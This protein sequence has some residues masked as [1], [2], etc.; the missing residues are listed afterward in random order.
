MAEGIVWELASKALES[1]S[2]AA[3]EEGSSWWGARSDLKKLE[4]TIR[5][6][7][8]RVRD[9]ERRQE[10]ENNESINL[11]LSRLKQVLYRADDLF[12]EII[13]LDRRN[14]RMEKSSMAK[15]FSRSGPIFNIKLAHKVNSIREELNDIKS[16][17]DVLNLKFFPAEELPPLMMRLIKERQTSSFVKTEDIIGRENDTKLIIGML[18][19]PKCE[20][21][22]EGEGEGISVI[23][24]V[25]FGGLGKTTL[26]QLVYNDEAV[27]KHF[28]VTTWVCV[29]EVD[30]QDAVMRRVYQAFTRDKDSGRLLVDEI[31]RG[32]RQSINNNKYLLVLDDIWDESRDRWL[33]LLRLLECGRKGSKVIVTTRSLTVAGVVGTK[34]ATYKLGLLTEEESWNL[35][36]KFAFESGQEERNPDLTRIG[37]EIV[38]SCGNVP[39]AIRVVGSLLY[40]KYS[41]KEWE[42]IRNS[43]LSKAKLKEGDRLMAVLKLSY[44]YLPPALKQCFAYCSLF[45]KDYRYE[46][47]NLVHLWMAQGYFEPS[48]N[49]DIGGQYFSELLG[50]NLFQD[51]EQD[52][53]GIET[54]KMHD[55]VHDLALFVAGGEIME[56][57]GQDAEDDDEDYMVLVGAGG[58]NIEL[59]EPL[60]REF[61]H[62]RLG[63]TKGA[64]SDGDDVFKAVTTLL[65]ARRMRSL[66]FD[67]GLEQALSLERVVLKCKSL[68][69][70]DFSYMEITRIPNSIGKLVHLRYLNLQHTHIECLPDAITKLDNLQTLNIMGCRRLKELP[71][72]FGK[73]TNLRYLINS[74]SGLTDLPSGFGKLTCLQELSKFMIGEGNGID[75]LPALNLVGNLDIEFNKWGSESVLEAKGAN[76][77]N[78][79]QLTCLKFSFN[80]EMEEAALGEMDKMLMCLQLPPNLEKLEVYLYKGVEMPRRWLDGLD[81][82]ISITI[83]ECNNCRVVPH[84][85]RLLHL[86]YL[87][88][89]FL[90]TLEYVEDDDIWVGNNVYF[91][92]LE[93]LTLQ[94]LRE[95]KGWTRPSK[96]D[97]EPRQLLF[98]C[99]LNLEV[100]EC[101]KLMSMPLAPMLES[102]EACNIHGTLFESNLTSVVDEEEVYLYKGVEMPR[103]WLDGLD[104]LVSINITGCQHCRVVPHMSRLLHLKD[105]H[106]EEL[107]TLEYVEDEDDIW[108][109]DSA[110]AAHNVY[111]P[112]LEVLTLHYL[113][114]LKGWKRPSKDYAEQRQLFP[115]LL[116]MDVRACPKLMSMPLAPMLESLKAYF[117]NGKLFE[118]NLASVE[119]EEE[120]S[121]SLPQSSS[122]S[123]LFTSLKHLEMR[124]IDDG[125][126]SLRISCRLCNLET[127]ELRHCD[128]LRSIT[129]GS[130]APYRNSI[131][132]PSSIRHLNIYYCNRLENISGGNLSVLEK[133]VIKGS[134]ENL[135]VEYESPNSIEDLDMGN[136]SGPE[137][138]KISC[139]KNLEEKKEPGK[140]TRSMW[141]QLK[142]LRRLELSSITKLKKIPKGI[143]CLTTLETLKIWSLSELTQLPEEMGNLSLLKIYDCPK[144]VLLPQSLLALTSLHSLEIG[145]CPDLRKRYEKPD[146]EDCHLIQH[147]PNVKFYEKLIKYFD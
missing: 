38:D 101:P 32:I 61:R 64:L 115:R 76:L 24:I 120:A 67:M 25:G 147:I 47:A 51:P 50:R 123:S 9:A 103:R 49:E 137:T 69:V 131:L 106:L 122:P 44:D 21:N 52:Y 63:V 81:K 56:L 110:S 20:Y 75:S 53:R 82:L 10:A 62:V 113:R 29:P 94:N 100:S 73:L 135:Y 95:L 12:D 139:S 99:L 84:M 126:V 18:F 43:Q 98:P 140:I 89:K 1:L 119:D 86:K 30:D 90:D 5:M 80:F 108:V 87:R 96:D 23:P 79:H 142:S 117:I 13:T 125:L 71:R 59:N 28:D 68:R 36:K 107:D 124:W 88:L 133:L 14:L 72:N 118:S 6:I 83:R 144:L 128:Q 114:E 91:P 2:K 39:L 145:N 136:M 17:M 134:C 45:P 37:K 105:L 141:Q 92:S 97:G 85:S 54:Y 4:D 33:D 121:S 26:A 22:G 40:S 111:F 16:D 7:Q 109:G 35:F 116:K 129:L 46:K 65:N 127:L 8:A 104:K 146:G 143:G 3:L 27:Q 34:E 58:E 48:N 66:L 102:L 70:L 132:L 130:S 57:Q 74:K 19:D 15:V 77:K 78:N 112:S 31:K 93:G 11:W 41:E 138:L 60:I 42:R 55:L